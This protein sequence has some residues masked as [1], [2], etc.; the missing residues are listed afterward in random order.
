VTAAQVLDFY[1]ALRGSGVRLWIDGGWCVDALLGEQ[2]REH[3]DLDVAVARSDDRALRSWFGRSGFSELPGGSQSV[4]VMAA[5]DGRRID[6]HLFEY[7]PNRENSWGVEYPWGSLSGLGRIGG[8]EVE[9]IAAEWMFEF[10]T[11][12][13][14]A[15][16]DLT[17]V[18]RLASRFG[19]VVPPT[20][21]RA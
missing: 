2:G 9:C 3:G 8:R 21:R 10:K 14:P 19:L 12:Y 13:A 17:D 7:G 16:K 1:F 6:V 4:Y 11:A 5:P 18:E 20:H 15:E